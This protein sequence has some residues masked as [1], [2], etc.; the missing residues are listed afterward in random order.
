MAFPYVSSL[1]VDFDLT[2]GAQLHLTN[3]GSGTYTGTATKFL[4]VDSSGNVI[5][6]DAPTGTVGGT[7]ST[8]NV[9]IWSDTNTLTTDGYFKYYPSSNLLETGTSANNVV[10]YP[11]RLYVENTSATPA[12]GLGVG[13]K[14]Q[15]EN[16]LNNGT[17]H[18]VGIIDVTFLDATDASEDAEMN[19]SVANAGTV[20]ERMTL[21][22]TGQLQLHAYGSTGLTGTATKWLAVD[23]GGN[24][25][26]EDAPGGGVAAIG[27]TSTSTSETLILSDTDIT[28]AIYEG[29]IPSRLVR[30]TVTWYMTQT[31]GTTPG[32]I[33]RVKLGS[34]TLDSTVPVTTSSGH[35]RVVFEFGAVSSTNTWLNMMHA[36]NTSIDN[37]SSMNNTS[38]IS[39][40]TGNGI[41]VYHQ[42]SGNGSLTVKTCTIELIG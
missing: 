1:Q 14:F 20:T 25:I 19:F 16:S 36:Y 12:A 35:G 39:H 21:K 6:E 29:N 10:G 5:E 30:V 15:L 11:Y 41:Y 3:Y 8:D 2:V 26:Q 40:G 37:S 33:F 18:D 27:H 42:M 13:I 4:A 22:N 23:A 28:N 7:G 38:S 9:A 24:I 32:I 17:Q 34:T 31:G